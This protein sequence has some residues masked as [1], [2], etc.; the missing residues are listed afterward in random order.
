MVEQAG[1]SPPRD[2]F[3]GHLARDFF[4]TS[5]GDS[6]LDVP[7]GSALYS[8]VGYRVWEQEFRPGLV[9]RVGENYPQ[10]WM[11]RLRSRGLDVRGIQILAESLDVRRFFQLGAD[12]EAALTNPLAHYSQLGHPLPPALVGYQQPDLDILDRRKRNERSLRK[13]DLPKAY[14]PATAVHL[15]PT[16]YLTHHLLPSVFRQEGLTTLTLDPCPEYMTPEFFPDLPALVTGLTAFLPAERELRS[17]YKRRKADLWD[18]AA[19]LASF[20]CTLVVIRKEA[21][22]QLLYIRDSDERWEVP[23]YPV[24]QVKQI[25]AGDAFCGGFLAGFRKTFDPLEAVLHG[26]VSASLVRGGLDPFY[27]L[28][29]MQRLPEA[30]LEALRKEVQQR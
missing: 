19:E 29:A 21:G 20:G 1:Y 10:A 11:D 30:R 15:A 4:V 28:D 18:M 8:A 27:A 13:Q 12:G 7:G 5:S 24:D 16:D 22:G 3:A 23:G 2:L 6:L 9:A 25:G 26:G 14:R 17:L